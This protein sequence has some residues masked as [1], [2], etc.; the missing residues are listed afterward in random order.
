MTRPSRPWFLALLLGLAAL[1][2]ASADDKWQTSNGRWKVADKCAR[3]AA[4][5]YPDYTA[6]SLA[7]RE[8]MRRNCLRANSLPVPD[9]PG[10]TTR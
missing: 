2:P 5:K 4:A 7:K 1:Q 8:A 9:G 6:E 10:P 3:D